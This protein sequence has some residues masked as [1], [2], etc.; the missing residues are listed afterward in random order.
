MLLLSVYIDFQLEKEK[1]KEE[2]EEARDR[3]LQAG[4]Y[5]RDLIL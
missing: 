5:I 2:E 3:V 4:S 1:Y